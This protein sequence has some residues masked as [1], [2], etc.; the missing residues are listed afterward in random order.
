MPVLAYL[1]NGF[2]D[3]P[4]NVA[5]QALFHI[6]Q[7]SVPARD[8]LSRLISAFGISRR[9]ISYVCQE[10]TENV[11]QP[12]IVGRDEN[13]QVVLMIEAK[14]WAG[15]TANQPVGYLNHINPSGLL[16]F[17]S[18]EVRLQELWSQ[19]LLRMRNRGPTTEGREGLGRTATV[20]DRSVAL[21]SWRRLLD[22]LKESVKEAG[23]RV[24]DS[25]LQQLSGL[26]DQMDTEAFFPLRQEE[27]SDVGH[28][29]RL[30]HYC[31][32]VDAIA[33]LA[34]QRAIVRKLATRGTGR[35]YSVDLRFGE[36]Q[37]ILSY[38]AEVW[39]KW[40][41]SPLWLSASFDWKDNKPFTA[42]ERAQIKS[43]FSIAD[44]SGGPLRE[45]DEQ[46]MI[47]ILL[48]AGVSKDEIVEDS[49]RQLGM[50]TESLVRSTGNALR[51]SGSP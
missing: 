23:D 29:K 40:G 12:D 24:A 31:E 45:A 37:V 25:D 11:G 28:A 16:L 35:Y 14:F 9:D 6:V 5:T 42:P 13:G 36:L 49:V 22:A 38:S 30:L 44:P 3:K 39:L 2:R 26:C 20:S 7:S 50:L 33:E 18:P 8:G 41:I 19:L 51:F 48:Q 4:E 27:I 47:P 17:V 21:I 46:F 32:L 34:R 10:R 1:M 15:L 43:A